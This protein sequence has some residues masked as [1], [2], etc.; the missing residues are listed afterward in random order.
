MSVKMLFVR[1]SP[2]RVLDFISAV[3]NIP[4]IWRG[5]ERSTSQVSTRAEDLLTLSPAKVSLYIVAD[6][7]YLC[8]KV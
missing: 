7:S 5:R 8:G 6:C 4:K 3:L 1:F 2:T